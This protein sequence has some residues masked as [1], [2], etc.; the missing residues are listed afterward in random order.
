M[1]WCGGGEI[2]PMPGGVAQPRDQFV[3]LVAGQL[4]A[5][6]GLGALR[7]LDLQHLGIDQVFG[8]DAEAAGGD[9]LDL[10]ALAVP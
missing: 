10:A 2:R 1:S 9:L 7:D 8:G 5:L 3:D 4:A 6:A